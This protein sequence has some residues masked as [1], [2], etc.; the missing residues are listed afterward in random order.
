MGKAV[1]NYVSVIILLT[2]TLLVTN[3]FIL[4]I[5]RVLKNAIR[6]LNSVDECVDK[7]VVEKAR[8][9]KYIIIPCSGSLESVIGDHEVL[10]N[11]TGVLVIR[12]SLDQRVVIIF[13]NGTWRG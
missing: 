7:I 3:G 5:D 12:A 8:L 9:Y 10:I 2:L 6:S 4:S 13:K 1:S 11:E